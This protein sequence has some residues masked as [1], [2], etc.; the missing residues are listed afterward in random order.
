MGAIFCSFHPFRCH[1]RFPTGIIL[2]VDE[3]TEL[4][5]SVLFTI[6][7]P[8]ELFQVVFA[9]RGQQVDVR[10]NSVRKEPLDLQCFTMIWVICVVEDVPTYQVFTWV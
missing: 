8:T 5:N 4:H 6:Q 9:T 2:L 7:I 3:H 10:T 1:P